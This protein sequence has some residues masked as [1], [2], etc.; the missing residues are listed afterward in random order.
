MSKKNNET[1]DIVQAIWN[2]VGGEEGARAL[3]S[4]RAK[5]EISMIELI[6]FCG[7][8]KIPATTERFVAKDRFELKGLGDGCPWLDNN[9]RDWFLHRDGKIEEPLAEQVLQYGTLSRKLS[10]GLIVEVLGGD[11]KAE[12]S[13]SEIFFLMG[14]QSNREEGALLT[15]GYTNI[16]FVK[17]RLGELRSV[18]LWWR[19][20]VLD[21]KANFIRNLPEWGCGVRVFSR[22]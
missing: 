16:F 7:T 5:M 12:C 2:M 15:D 17:D 4:G 9:F 11:A 14:R 20:G 13:L 3:V 19:D 1:P 10:E 8:I 21:I 6:D 18:C 22:K